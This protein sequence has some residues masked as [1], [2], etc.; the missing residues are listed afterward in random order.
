MKIAA[1]HPA[2]Y[3]EGL[4][5]AYKTFVSPGTELTLMCATDGVFNTAGDVDL[6]AAEAAILARRAEKD[7]YDAV[8]VC[9]MCDFALS[10]VRGA[11]DIPAVGP[12]SATYNL[13]Y[14]LARRFG[15]VSLNSKWNPA[16]YHAIRECGCIE[17]M[18]SMRSLARPMAVTRSGIETPY[19]QEEWEAQILEI[20]KV[21]V[22]QEDAQ[23]IVVACAPVFA[24]LLAPGAQQRLA[25]AL[26]VIV[27]DPIAIAFATAEMLVNLGLSHS[28]LE[29]PRIEAASLEDRYAVVETDRLRTA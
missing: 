5:Q 17:R 24:T 16:F 7:G 3:D 8:V 21:Q 27:V 13:V 28:K 19:T 14:Q 23:C 6:K 12:A 15:V 22:E 1:I 25:A 9:G 11:V 26:G 2:R 20:A 18:T 29:Y 4:E 10:A